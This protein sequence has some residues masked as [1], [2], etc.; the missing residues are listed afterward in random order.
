MA[1]RGKTNR[2]QGA[3]QHD[4]HVLAETVVEFAHGWLGNSQAD[5]AKP[6]DCNGKNQRYHGYLD[7][8]ARIQAQRRGGKK[9]CPAAALQ[10]PSR[11]PSPANSRPGQCRRRPKVLWHAKRLARPARRQQNWRPA[12]L[13]E[14]HRKWRTETTPPRQRARFPTSISPHRRGLLSQSRSPLPKR[15]VDET[16]PLQQSANAGIRAF[17]CRTSGRGRSAVPCS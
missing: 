4:V 15:N 1:K 11:R 9:Q 3:S 5:K 6:G 12:A 13:P 16:R 8:P 2:Y 14:A 7:W 17:C 10:R